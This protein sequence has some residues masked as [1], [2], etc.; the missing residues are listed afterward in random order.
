MKILAIDPSSTSTGWALF[1]DKELKE[2]G[3]VTSNS[4]D[5]VSKITDMIYNLN[6][7]FFTDPLLF[8]DPNK[9]IIETN[10]SCYAKNIKRIN[11]YQFVAGSI[12]GYYIVR[13][14]DNVKLI[15]VKDWKGKMSE[16]AVCYNAK[17]V[18]N[19]DTINK[20]TLTAIWLGH[21]Y[22]SNHN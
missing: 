17:M 1:E 14:G 3:V 11:L 20:D 19:P 5:L 2:Y 18:Y 16:D 21:W 4:K 22:I 15:D 8:T 7:L 13:Y 6:D 9:I 10:I 12:A